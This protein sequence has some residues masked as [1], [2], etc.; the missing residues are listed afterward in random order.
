MSIRLEN[1]TSPMPM[2]CEDGAGEAD[3]AGPANSAS[4]AAAAALRRRT[5]EQPGRLAMLPSLGSLHS[6]SNPSFSSSGSIQIVDSAC[7]VPLQ[8][9]GEDSEA[10]GAATA[11]A[12]IDTNNQLDHESRER[13]MADSGSDESARQSLA[14]P[15][16]AVPRPTSTSTAAATL[17]L[18]PSSTSMEQRRS[19]M[20]LLRT[21]RRQWLEDQAWQIEMEEHGQHRLVQH[22]SAVAEAAAQTAA[23]YFGSPIPMSASSGGGGGDGSSVGTDTGRSSEVDS[24]GHFRHRSISITGIN[25]PSPLSQRFILNMP[26]PTESIDDARHQD[27]AA[28]NEGQMQVWPRAK[29]EGVL[30]HE[31]EVEY[32]IG[33][34]A[35]V[36]MEDNA[37]EEEDDDDDESTVVI[38]CGGVD[39]NESFPERGMDDALASKEDRPQDLPPVFKQYPAINLRRRSDDGLPADG[40]YPI[41]RGSIGIPSTRSSDSLFDSMY[42]RSSDGGPGVEHDLGE[43][44]VMPCRPRSSEPRLSTHFQGHGLRPKMASEAAST[45]KPAAPKAP[46]RAVGRTVPGPAPPPPPIYG[47]AELAKPEKPSKPSQNKPA[48]QHLVTLKQPL[49]SD[50]AEISTKYSEKGDKRLERIGSSM[51]MEAMIG[52]VALDGED[53]GVEVSLPPHLSADGFDSLREDDPCSVPTAAGETIPSRRPRPANVS[54]FDR[55]NSVVDEARGGDPFGGSADVA[56]TTG[57]TAFFTP[58]HVK[59]KVKFSAA[60]HGSKGEENAPPSSRNS[61]M[62]GGSPPLSLPVGW[63]GRPLPLQKQ[64]N[65]S[66]FGRSASVGGV[67]A[68][69]EHNA[70]SGQHFH[71]PG[72]TAP[73]RKASAYGRGAKDFQS[74]LAGGQ[75][76]CSDQLYGDFQPRL[77]SLASPMAMEDDN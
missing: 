15:S 45:F 62:G 5:G 38:D 53:G 25:L 69:P 67:Y 39:N 14:E 64:P 56:T 66:S 31:S 57:G 21:R 70:S 11:A 28:M 51:Q 13:H 1:G 22:P 6:L 36:C 41:T 4:A 35:D 7:G 54:T 68:S 10:M 59:T 48:S 75:Q 73:Q 32:A 34:G 2:L 71:T 24:A 12:G 58:P 18:Q 27:A 74:T 37:K 50:S 61:R 47:Q 52:L 49:L 42:R 20:S 9:V 8:A 77:P 43:D 72:E 76:Q 33:G 17:K 16:V 29:D 55:S 30:V 44:F 19:D 3:A 60:V 40:V 65:T 46:T 26:L 23:R 63:P